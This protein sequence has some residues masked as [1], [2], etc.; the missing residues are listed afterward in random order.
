MWSYKT[1]HFG[2]QR[3]IVSHM[4]TDS[5][6]HVPHVAYSYEPDVTEFL[7]H[8]KKL[9]ESR[10]PEDKVTLNS[11]ILKTIAM[12][13]KVA[14]YL[15]AYIE[16]NRNFVTGR[17]DLI[18]YVNVSMPMTMP[19]GEMMTVNIRDVDK[20]SL[21]EI[22]ETVRSVREKFTRTDL[23]HA[24]Y[25]VSIE[26][27]MNNLRQGHF[28]KT[29][30][31]LAGSLVGK[32]RVNHL[33][34]EERRAYEQIPPTERLTTRDL[35]QGTITISNIGSLYPAQTGVV[36][37]IEIV[38][39]QV[40]AFGVSAA[41]DRAVPVKKDDGSVEI[42]IRKVMPICIV[43]DHRALDFGEVVPF[44]KRLDEIF[45]NPEIMDTW[46]EIAPK[47]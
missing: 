4:T 39:P 41:Q 9:N 8:F 1:I 23:E 29:A 44:I 47:K 33:R 46:S 14:P 21:E 18:D 12:G 13:V 34:G 19:T 6:R 28:I 25:E 7:A 37:L 38:P 16:F 17:L 32:H 3:K 43:F 24:M 26:N 15:N 45:A 22:G 31:R 30:M 11:L 36:N 35:R 5:W 10:A 20:K 40:A 27:T 42:E 2:I